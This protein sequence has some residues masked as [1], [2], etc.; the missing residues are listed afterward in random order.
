MKTLDLE[1]AAGTVTDYVQGALTEPVV[2]TVAGKPVAALVPMAGSDNETAGL[3]TSER[4]LALVERSRSRLRAEGAI[5]SDDM[6]KR[7]G[8]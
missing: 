4:F 3:C 2:F 7:L 6:R 8:L 1:S 5:S